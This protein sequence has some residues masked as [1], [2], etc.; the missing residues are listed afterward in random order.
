MRF[1]SSFVPVADTTTKVAATDGMIFDKAGNV[2]FADLENNKI[3][4]RKLPMGAYI[5]WS[6]VIKLNGQTPLVFM[7]TIFKFTN[8]RVNEAADEIS[9]MIF[10][11]NNIQLPSN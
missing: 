7:L 2:Y 6:K 5:L 1:C 9:N 10:N 8:S 11:L 4:Y 3:Q